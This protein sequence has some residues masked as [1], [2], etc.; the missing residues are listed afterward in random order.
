MC[1]AT[2]PI[3]L[4]FWNII[5]TG[6]K[7]HSNLSF[8]SSSLIKSFLKAFCTL[9]TK[10]VASQ[11][12]LA[13][14]YRLNKVNVRL[15]KYKDDKVRLCQIISFYKFPHGCKNML[16]ANTLNIYALLFIQVTRLDK[17]ARSENNKGGNKS[18]KFRTR[19]TNCLLLV[20][21]LN[22]FGNKPVYNITDS[23]IIF[24]CFFFN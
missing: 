1:C 10:G 12:F 14:L 3:F 11:S 2:F 6:E 21:A 18:N 4:L 20:N 19:T 7:A 9:D 15:E 16:W 5:L 23:W 8:P 24:A 22:W 17:Q 13:F